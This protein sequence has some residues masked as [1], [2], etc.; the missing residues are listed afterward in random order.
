[1]ELTKKE[2]KERRRKE[3]I[4]EEKNKK[5]GKQAKLICTFASN[6]IKT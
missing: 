5:Y 2:E 1:M 4:E 6:T 3:K